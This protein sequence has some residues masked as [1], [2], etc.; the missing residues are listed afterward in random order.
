MPLGGNL[1]H[2]PLDEELQVAEQDEG[3]RGRG[4]ALVLLYEV[5]ALELPDLVRVLLHL[6][7]RV[8]GGRQAHTG[9]AG[10]TTTCPSLPATAP[11]ADARC[12]QADGDG[13]LAGRRILS[14]LAAK[15][16]TEREHLDCRV[17][18][19]R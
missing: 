17:C 19:P 8:A 15:V 16:R 3:R 11:R 18:H 5:V 14:V 1:Q 10:R 12:P 13:R 2:Q 6:L 7:E 9:H 4:P